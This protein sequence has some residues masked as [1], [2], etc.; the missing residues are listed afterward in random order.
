LEWPRL[1]AEGTILSDVTPPAWAER[2]L[3]LVVRHDHHLNV[4]GDLLEA[5]REI[6]YPSRGR[7]G[8][9]R[10]YTWQ[11]AQFVWLSVRRWSV[12]FSA[13]FIGRTMLDWLV[14]P[15]DFANR[16]MVTTWMA[17]A[18]VAIPALGAAF[19][20][21][22]AASGIFAA[23]ACVGLAA[24]LSIAGVAMI[25]AI[26]LDS[27]TLVAIR[28]SGGLPEALTLPILV[29]LPATVIGIFA[30][31]AGATASRLISPDDQ[32]IR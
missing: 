8:A 22:S 30:G 28:N 15:N 17:A 3:R 20:C 10:W 27:T 9:D 6:I 23:V 16:A 14:P 2:V 11:I 26:W 29:A 32:P 21:R 1:A 4:S 19:R 13:V 7:G 12:L 5:Y 31:I 18:I 25:L 24:P